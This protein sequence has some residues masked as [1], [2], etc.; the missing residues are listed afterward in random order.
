MSRYRRRVVGIDD[1]NVTAF[2]RCKVL[3]LSQESLHDFARDILVKPM[4]QIE[5]RRIHR[6]RAYAIAFMADEDAVR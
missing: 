2:Y 4:L 1:S 5:A 6:H 3:V